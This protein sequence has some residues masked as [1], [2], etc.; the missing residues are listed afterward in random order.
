MSTEQEMELPRIRLHP[1][2]IVI[3][4]FVIGGAGQAVWVLDP[5]WGITT[6]LRNFGAGTMVIGGL[7]LVFAYGTM[8]RAWTTINPR[9]HT[10]AIVTDG[11]Y[12]FSRNP[13]YVG[14]FLVILGAGLTN[15]SLFEVLVACVMMAL[16]RW[17]V[18]LPE[19]A[20]L[21]RAFG[22]EYRRYKRS[23]RRWV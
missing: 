2:V 12:R 8:A 16:L 1:F 23:V 7:I 11:V 5:S 9:R 15:G 18:V 6:P 14:W 21:E 10:R 4:A 20:Y 13:I 3:G 17:A 22:D 19:E